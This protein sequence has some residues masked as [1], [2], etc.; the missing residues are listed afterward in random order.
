MSHEI[1]LKLT[2]DPTAAKRLGRLEAVRNRMQGRARTRRL[3]STYYDTADRRLRAA[4]IALRIRHVG[5]TR[6]L[7][8]KAKQTSHGCALVRREWEGRVSYD[9]PTTADI[10]DPELR[11][12]V[13]RLLVGPTGVAA[14]EPLFTS[15]MS[16]TSRDLQLDGARAVMDVDTGVVHAGVPGAP[17]DPDAGP[18]REDPVCELELELVEGDPAAL[19]DFARELSGV[20]DLRLSIDTKAARGFRLIEGTA[21]TSVKA[22]ALELRPAD[23]VE[24][25][26]SSIV[27]TCLG[28]VIANQL[29]VL[30]NDD[31]EGVHQMRVG[32]R[33]LR[34]ALTLFKDVIPEEQ[35]EGIVSEVRWLTSELGRS[36]DADVQAAEIV[37]PVAA[38]MKGDDAFAHLLALL[39]QEKTDG[40]AAA[41]TAVASQR[42]SDLI[43]EASS[44]MAHR[45]WRQ[46]PLSAASA[47][48][49]QP[50]TELACRLLAQRHKKVVKRARK[51]SDLPTPERHELRKDVKKLRYACEFFR[52]L[53]S[54]KRLSDYT[55]RL[56]GL[57]DALGYLNDVAVAEEFVAHLVMVAER[58]GGHDL[59]YAAGV[60]LGWHEHALAM[61]EPRILEQ[62][63]RFLKARPFWG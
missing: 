4:G 9:V 58:Q 37:G 42:V 41:R 59:Q 61:E 31:P 50:V 27:G 12:A 24:S 7:C 33:R 46:Q 52:S 19:F 13:E 6:L 28:Q 56:A 62:L 38:R 20:V 57:Q 30:A 26:F 5:R 36:R 23:T 15:A 3:V 16:R 17:M 49:F 18:R 10:A 63:G 35:R 21:P 32:L 2:L 45:R 43:L 14:L 25:A 29:P 54:K 40:R 48:L 11:L 8:V 44:W 34:S 22:N 39:Q 53:Y 1:E 55:K 47:L 51:F 60:V